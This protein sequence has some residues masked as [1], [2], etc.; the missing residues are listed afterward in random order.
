MAGFSQKLLKRFISGWVVSIISFIVVLQ[1]GFVFLAY[2]GLWGL[3]AIFEWVQLALKTSNRIF[4][5]ASGFVYIFISLACVYILRE[6]YPVQYL[7]LFF[8]M[9]AFSD[10]GAYAAGKSI[11]GPKMASEISPN[12]TW[13]GFFGAVAS[14]AIIGVLFVAIFLEFTTINVALFAALGVVM[15]FVGQSGDLIVSSLKR[16]AGAKDTGGIIPGHGGVLDRIDAML[17]AVP[18][19]LATMIGFG[20]VFGL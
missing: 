20:H 18:V 17:L 9:V 15:G 3:V 13:A 11:G 10:M 8:F 2:L 7:V 5:S 4:F 1:G 19:F 12:K 6:Q 14:P 16:Q